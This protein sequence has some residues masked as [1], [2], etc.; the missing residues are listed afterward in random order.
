MPAE[1]I[2]LYAKWDANQYTITFDS[3]G[4]S[5]V[6]SITQDYNTTVSAPN[7][8]TKEGYTFNNWYLDNELTQVY[9]FTTMPAENITLYAKWTINQYTITFESNGGSAVASITQDYNTTV[10]A[11]NEPTKEGC[12]F[13]GW[14]QVIPATMPSENI[15]IQP[16]W[17][18]VNQE[19]G[20]VL[21]ETEEVYNKIDPLLIQGK[22]VEITVMIEIKSQTNVSNNEVDAIA[23]LVKNTLQIDRSGSLFINI[24]IILKEIGH[25][26]VP[27]QELLEPLSIVISIPQ[28]HRGYQNY[29]IVRIH[30]GVTEALETIYDETAQT[31]TFESDC[32]STYAIVYDASNG[33]GLWWFMLLLII[34]LG[35]CYRHAVLKHSKK[36]KGVKQ[37]HVNT[38]M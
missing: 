21:L 11:P 2:T 27:V 33:I 18:L 28:E 20:N 8:P 32:F 1:N 6:A 25:N 9:T 30:N 26:N 23:D 22:N 3:N 14:S 19:T 15:T 29:H 5:A 34:P 35:Y 24:E 37:E 17:I 13:N 16:F 12:V 7:E 4:G 36:T 38:R 10:S 31:L